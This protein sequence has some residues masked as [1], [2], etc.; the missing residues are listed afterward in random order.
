MPGLAQPVVLKH[1][2]T[3]APCLYV[4]KGFTHRILDVPDQESAALLDKLFEH[5]KR[6]EFIY[7]HRWQ[8]GDLLIWDNYSTQHRATGG[9]ALP[10]RRP[11]VAHDDPGFPAPVKKRP[12]MMEIRQ[13]GTTLMRRWMALCAAFPA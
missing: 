13:L 7:R 11:H 2:V 10:Q 9:Y 1:P 6:E 3:R 8:A 4:N 12:A 5:A